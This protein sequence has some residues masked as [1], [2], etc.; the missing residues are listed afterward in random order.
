M[1]ILAF[2]TSCDDTS[3]ALFENSELISM[4]TKSQIK[5]HNKTGGVVPEVASREHANVI[6]EVLDD[7]LAE[8]NTTLQ[9][10]DYI[11]VT[12]HPGLVPSLLTGITVASTISQTLKI[13]II[14]IDHIQA[15]IFS[16]WLERDE[17]EIQFPLV[18]LTVSGGH[19]EVWFMSDMWTTE[20]LGQ[21]QDDAAGEAFDK[22]AKMMGLGYPGG[23]II[24]KLASEYIGEAT[25]LF[26]RVYLEKSEFG[27]SFSGLKS[28][29][30]REVDKRGELTL[31][32]QRGISSEF[33][34]AVNEVLCFKL[35]EAARQKGVETVLLAGGVS[36]NDD[37]NTKI[38][39]EAQKL[40]LK[41][42]APAKKLYCMD[43]AAMIGILA[44]YRVKYGQFEEKY[45]V[46]EIGEK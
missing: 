5:I 26:P 44:Y 40:G 22:V 43:N 37:L 46:V 35:F 34:S 41:F 42:F 45:G 21:T 28:A 29:V 17:S 25:K 24:S 27:F 7:V 4:H 12:T 10:I 13:P 14:P 36:A 32:D 11:A 1:K 3:I 33:Q 18:C 2:E 6:F 31:E 16:N 19:N 9:E 39:G 38:S 15:H 23:P 30:K 20:K 8:G